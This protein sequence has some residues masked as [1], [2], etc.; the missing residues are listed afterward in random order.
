MIT[1]LELSNFRAFKDQPFSFS[2]LNIF[3]GPNNSGKS[4]IISSLNILAQSLH[5]A[6]LIDSPLTIN[7]RYD[8]LGTFKDMVHGGRAS[9]PIKIGLSIADYTYDFEVKYRLQRREMEISKFKLQRSRKAI[10]E[11]TSGRDSYDVRIGGIDQ[12]GLFSTVKKTRPRFTGYLPTVPDFIRN[13]RFQSPV[14]NL[15]KHDQDFLRSIETDIARFRNR[16]LRTF[17]NYETLGAFREVPKRT[18]LWSGETAESIGRFGENSITILSSD[19][20]KKGAEQIGYVDQ[21]SEW[22]RA[23]GIAKG[24]KVKHLTD[25]HF[26]VV[27]TGNDGLDHNIADVGFGC[28]QVLPVLISGIKS[29]NRLPRRAMMPANF[30]LAAATLV[31]QEP[32]IHLHPNAQAELGTFFVR[33]SKMGPQ[34][35][36]ETH[37]DSLVL[38]VARHVISGD[39]SSNDVR[40]FFLQDNAGVKLVTPLSID[41]GGGFTPSWPGGFFPQRQAES[42]ELARAA[43]RSVDKKA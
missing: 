43:M 5:P 32:E 17:E 30:G 21:V 23:T 9:T 22:L 40:I 25:R 36:I 18:Y 13:L 26:E 33:I 7:G 29:A 3:V 38:R 35:F 11:Y 31:I 28:S 42:F 24:I 16:L 39:I 14:P 2:K 4:S 19:S 15:S 37:S 8:Q 10:Y 34:I 27:I 41:S 6:H 1:N 20:L 12:D